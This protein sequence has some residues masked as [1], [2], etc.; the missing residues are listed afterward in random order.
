MI[1]GILL[2]STSSCSE[3]DSTEVLPVEE[4]KFQLLDG[5]GNDIWFGAGRLFQADS[6]DVFIIREGLRIQVET[7]VQSSASA[8]RY[9]G[10]KLL[11]SVGDQNKA[12]I[13]LSPTDSL[14]FFYRTVR[15]QF[16]CQ[17][18]QEV[19]FVLQG[20]SVVCN[21]CGIPVLDGGDGEFIQLTY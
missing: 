20:D 3:C 16:N 14:S 19:S 21:R 10:F 18:F 9:V 5:F 2:L 11:A 1:V 17:E 15:D 7:N 8:K 12:T 13:V 4:S 6:A